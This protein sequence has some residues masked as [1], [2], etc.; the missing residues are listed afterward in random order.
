MKNQRLF[1]LLRHHPAAI[2]LAATAFHLGLA[3]EVKLEPRILDSYTG[4]YEAEANRPFIIQRQGNGLTCRIAAEGVFKLEAKSEKDFQFKELPGMGFTFVKDAKGK[5]TC[6]VFH[7][8]GNNYNAPK[9]SD[10]PPSPRLP[11]L[12]KIPPRD[13]KAKSNLLDLSGKYN[14]RL[15]DSWQ[16]DTDNPVLQQ[17]HLGAMPQGMRR[18]GPIEFDVRGVVQLNNRRI[19]W[20]G[21]NAAG[22]RNR[23]SLRV[24]V[25][26]RDNPH[27]DWTIESV[28]LVS[29]MEDSALF[30]IAITVE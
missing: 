4:Q 15:D 7:K 18:F 11:D 21:A 9:V 12:R 3:A 23:S 13:P 2:V 1:H 22:D 28:D 14:G 19:A 5:V 10:Q 29:A 8:D 17:N 25:S 6:L 24:F 27:P 30:L 20:K 16:P 26:T